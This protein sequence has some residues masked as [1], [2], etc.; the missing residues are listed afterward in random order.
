M[1]NLS[2]KLQYL[3]LLVLLSLPCLVCGQTTPLKNLPHVAFGK[4]QIHFAEEYSS[5][6][7]PIKKIWNN[8]NTSPLFCKNE[9]TVF[10]FY[11]GSAKNI[12]LVGDFSGW[13]PQGY[14]FEQISEKQF[15]IELEFAPTARVEYKLIVDGNWITDPLN[16]NKVDNGV[17]GENSFFTMPDYKPTEWAEGEIPKLETIE[18]DSKV[19]GE[20]RK[21]Q[22]Y[23]PA[24]IVEKFKDYP[25]D[26]PSSYYK[27]NPPPPSNT[28]VLY[29]QDGNDYIH[30]AK[31]IQ[32]QQNLVKAKR[33]QPFVMVF[34]D[35]KDRMKEYWAND[36]YAKFLATE[37]VPLIDDKF[38]IISLNARENRGII[39]A[40]LGGITA[41]HT[42][43]KY[44]QIF[45]RIG[46]QSCSFWIDNERVVEDIEK[47]NGSTKFRF[48]L[49]DGMLEGVE[50]TRKVVGILKQNG[51]DVTYNEAEAGHNW[52]A[53]K[54]RLA[55]AY[56]S[57]WK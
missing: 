9:N 26:K 4:C 44:P 22:I 15:L 57:I 48:Y 16:P 2:F 17:G 8:G 13:K 50:D 12:E 49:D 20:K 30:K 25:R 47:L 1:W 7:K 6:G 11:E 36:D 46:G 54:D 24:E 23:T 51:F 34:I 53:W 35:P 18:I 39:G 27:N 21:I 41:I 40:S 43:L 45:G 5:D 42:A 28:R 56:L 19:Y 52:T 3:G 32:I 29:F 55:D 38:W 31:A 14:T 37:V 33:I 10:L